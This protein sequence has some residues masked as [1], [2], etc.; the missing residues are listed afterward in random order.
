ME[1][2]EAEVTEIEKINSNHKHKL[3]S[4]NVRN[5]VNIKRKVNLWTC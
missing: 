3:A 1:E 4:V 5:T 2:P